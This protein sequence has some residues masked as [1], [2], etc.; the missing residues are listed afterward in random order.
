[1]NK[2][3]RK[4]VKNFQNFGFRFGMDFLLHKT[5][6]RKSE[7]KTRKRAIDLLD[8]QFGSIFSEEAKKGRNTNA[9]EKN[10][11]IFWDRGF[12][13]LPEI[14]AASLASIERFYKDD[15]QIFKITLQNYSEFVSI[16]PHIVDLFEKG[17]ISIQAFS[18]ILR[19]QL[20]HK[21]GGVW[22]DATMLFFSKLDFPQ[23]VSETGF[24]SLNVDCP[25]KRS[26]WGRVFPVTY[27]TFFFACPSK[28]SILNAIN[29]A[30]VAYF[31]KYDFPIDYFLN[32]YFFI[33][34]MKHL[35]E[36]GALEKIPFDS[37]DPFILLRGLQQGL[38]H[39]S[40]EPL[41]RTPQK[42][43]WKGITLDGVI[44]G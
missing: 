14:P 25:E 26:L 12:D 17:N 1:M 23:L 7:W 22:C 38:K 8:K 16:D 18:D 13:S 19:F 9:F 43:T 21:Y 33:L 29:L 2:N 27:T 10:I 3:I 37:G 31:Q 44:Y 41:K 42:L 39:F 24:Y 15:Y 20:L 11:F 5:V 32:D 35:V 6:F 36:D 28:S 40:M 30:Y 4:V 34:A